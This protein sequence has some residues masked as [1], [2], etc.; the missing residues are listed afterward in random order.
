M[1]LKRNQSQ[2]ERACLPFGSVNVPGQAGYCPDQQ[3]H[4]LV[5]RQVLSFPAFRKMIDTL[6]HDR[7]GVHDF[8]RN[9][10]LLP[11]S[12]HAALRAGLPLHRGPHR[13]YNELV[14]ERIGQI[15]ADWSQARRKGSVTADFTAL[16]RFDLLQRALRRRFL[17][18]RNWSRLPLNTRD[19]SLDFS[20]LDDMAELFWTDT[21]AVQRA[22]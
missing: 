22:N 18:P 7:L 20:H 10:Q 21:A 11:G 14:I 4:H 19:P 17:D 12:E 3:R 5:P 2:P 6:G 8:R 1:R 13:A 15:E 16:M 9:G